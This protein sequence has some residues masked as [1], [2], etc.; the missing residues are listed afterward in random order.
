LMTMRVPGLT[1]PP[2]SAVRGPPPPLSPR[3]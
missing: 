2:S 3:P 1:R